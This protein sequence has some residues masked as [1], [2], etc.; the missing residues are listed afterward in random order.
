MATQKQKRAATESIG[1]LLIV[2]GI[3]IVLNV[4]ATY[5]DV[6]R[7][8]LTKS[9]LFSLADGSARVV[10]SLEDRMEITAYFTP[11]LPPPYNATERHVRD[12]LAEY[13]ARSGGHLVVRFV[14]PETEEERRAAEQDGVQRIAHQ[15][16]EEDSVSVVEG[17][18][19][20]VIKYLGD[21]K[22]IFL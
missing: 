11:D 1:F 13:R 19:G 14:H 3:M 16:L 10:E 8:D 7:I 6:G 9:R 22:T 5:F 17:Y 20:L 18:R 2:G 21:K 12:L 4:I 15:K